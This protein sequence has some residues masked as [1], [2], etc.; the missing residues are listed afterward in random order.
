MEEI[1]KGEVWGHSRLF[2]RPGTSRLRALRWFLDLGKSCYFAELGR[3]EWKG[4]KEH[5]MGTYE[6]WDI[7]G[8]E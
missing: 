2:M 6:Q 5:P 4:W 8:M 1:G 7:K 3:M